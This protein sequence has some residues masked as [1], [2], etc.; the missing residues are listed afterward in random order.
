[1]LNIQQLQLGGCE[2]TTRPL[3]QQQP[4]PYT[5]YVKDISSILRKN[6]YPGSII[7]TTI[8]KKITLFNLNPEE[9]SKSVQFTWSSLRLVKNFFEFWKTN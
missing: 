4:Y 5:V 2:G 7:E 9:A 3:G 8:A 6:G 1:M